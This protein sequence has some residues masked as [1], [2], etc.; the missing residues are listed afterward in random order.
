MPSIVYAPRITWHPALITTANTS[1]IGTG[2]A[3]EVFRA[4]VDSFVQKLLF[5]PA[6][7]NVQSV[8]RVFVNNG[9][10]S[11]QPQNNSP[12]AEVSLPA[13][14]LSETA[15]MGIVELELGIVVPAGYV[16]LV[17]IGTS[18]SAGYYVTAIAGDYQDP[19]P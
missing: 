10:D 2:S 8:G 3:A 6:G 18:V 14:T 19:D 5:V 1:K 4:A 9:Q 17:T 12:V 11:N 15:A 7:T 16:L 13:T